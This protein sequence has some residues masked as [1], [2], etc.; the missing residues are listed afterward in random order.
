MNAITISTYLVI[1][2]VAE[3][4]RLSVP[5]VSQTQIDGLGSPD[6][7]QGVDVQASDFFT[8]QGKYYAVISEST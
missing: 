4:Y 5:G 1:N 6:V 8:L 7:H 3:T 2:Y